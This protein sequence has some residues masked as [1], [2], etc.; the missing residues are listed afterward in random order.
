M[1]PIASLQQSKHLLWNEEHSKYLSSSILFLKFSTFPTLILGEMRDPPTCCAIGG[2]RWG[3]RRERWPSLG[4]WS[5]S[6]PSVQSC[7]LGSPLHFGLSLLCF[8]FWNMSTNLNDTFSILRQSG[9]YLLASPVSAFVS[10]DDLSSTGINCR[11]FVRKTLYKF[12]NW[13]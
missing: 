10:V 11:H 3:L 5:C 4:F 1:W 7:T 2:R 8:I 13:V 9:S 6:R 12:M